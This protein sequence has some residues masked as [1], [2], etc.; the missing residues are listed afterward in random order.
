MKPRMLL[1]FLLYALMSCTHIKPSAP[2]L[3]P[4]SLLIKLDDL[5]YRAEILNR[6]QIKNDSKMLVY[7][8]KKAYGGRK[9]IS[10]DKLR[11][12]V[13][14]IE[15]F[16]FPGLSP[17]E[18]FDLIGKALLELPDNHIHAR[19]EGK[20]CGGKD[21]QAHGQV[22]ENINAGKNSPWSISEKDGIK[23]ISIV[24]MPSRKSKIWNG[25]TEALK[26][27][28][29]KNIKAYIIDL[30][31]NDGGDDTRGHELSAYFFGQDA[32]SFE[33]KIIKSTTP[34]TKAIRYN[35]KILRV[36]YLN[37]KGKSIPQYLK[38]D[39][40]ELK[41]EFEIAVKNK[42]HPDKIIKL[43]GP[44]Y[45]AKKAIKKPIF[46][47]IDKACASSCESIIADF[48]G[49]PYAK[50]VGENSGGFVQFGNM[51]QL[52][53]KK[54]GVIVQM[55]SDFWQYKDRKWREFVGF[56]PDI[57]I[58]KGTDAYKAT[59]KLVESSK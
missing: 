35:S 20:L 55:A 18:F 37:K 3:K 21:F 48:K 59:L 26:K 52:L 8:L 27:L 19:Y 54:S 4:E 33:D 58:P 9:F 14:K 23:I 49:H 28:R 25:Y 12:V 57:K 34:E 56:T 29:N 31:G 30:R 43:N 46:I 39:V 10:K 38:Q 5:S 15:G 16:N 51:G 6:M 36:Y 40:S 32:P 17:N 44:S 2:Q 50:L 24:G 13:D 11:K 22:G 7:A 42:D 47:L 41:A 45:D 1:F 53:L